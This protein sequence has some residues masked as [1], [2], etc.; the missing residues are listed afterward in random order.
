MSGRAYKNPYVGPQPLDAGQKIYGRDRELARLLNLMV[1][2]R[3]VVLHSPSGAGKSSLI[4]AGLVPHLEEAAGEKKK[5]IAVMGVVRIKGSL[6]DE[7][8][9]AAAKRS[10]PL[11]RFILSVVL[12]LEQALPKDVIRLKPEKLAR[13]KLE[14]YLDGYLE[15]RDGEA[16][17]Q[18][19]GLLI[20]DQFEDLITQD[21]YDTEAKEAFFKE[22]GRA[23]AN[24]KRAA[25]FT[26][27]EDYLAAL[28]PFA[29]H[30]PT[31]LQHTFRMDLLTEGQ[32]LEAIEGPAR[33]RDV[34]FEK[35]LAEKLVNDLRQVR[36]RDS[37]GNTKVEKGPH[38]EPVHLQ[39]LCRDLWKRKPSEAKIIQASLVDK[40]WNVDDA[41]AD[42]YDDEVDKVSRST[43]V[44]ER[45]IREWVER[46]LI[47]EDG[48]RGQVMQPKKWERGMEQEAL[49]ALVDAHL[50][51]KEVRRDIPWYELTHDRMVAPVR[52][53]NRR[54]Q[55]RNLQPFMLQALQWD[56][57]KGDKRRL[58][59]SDKELQRAEAWL[60]KKEQLLDDVEKAFLS[61]SR[62]EAQT[63]ATERDRTQK[64]EQQKLEAQQN[65]QKLDNQLQLNKVSLKSRR[66]LRFMLFITLIFLVLCVLAIL[67][68][69]QAHEEALKQ[70]ATLIV[71]NAED[72]VDEDPLLGTL[73]LIEL[74]KNMQYTGKDREDE[75]RQLPPG[76]RTT[77]LRLLSQRIPRMTFPPCRADTRVS[78]FGKKGTWVVLA[79]GPTARIHEEESG[80]QLHRKSLGKG[81][82]IVHLDTIGDGSL[83]ALVSKK[84][85]LWLWD[86]EADDLKDMDLG[87]HQVTGARFS[88]RGDR[89]YFVTKKRALCHKPLKGKKVQCLPITEPMNTARLKALQLSSNGEYLAALSDKGPVEILAVERPGETACTTSKSLDA[90]PNKGMRFSGDGKKL[91]T[92]SQRQVCTWDSSTCKQRHCVTRTHK[93]ATAYVLQPDGE[94][95]LMADRHGAVKVLDFGEGGAMKPEEVLRGHKAKVVHMSFSGG[96]QR[97]LT[98]SRDG[99]TFIWPAAAPSSPAASLSEEERRRFQETLASAGGAI[100]SPD[101]SLKIELKDGKAVLINVKH[102]RRSPLKE[103]IRSVSLACFSRG[104]DLALG[105]SDGTIYIF[106]LEEGDWP[107]DRDKMQKIK[108]RGHTTGLEWMTFSRDSQ[109]LLTLSNDG[110]ARVWRV[111]NGEP[112]AWLCGAGKITGAAFGPDINSV[113]IKNNDGRDRSWPMSWSD[114]T[115]RL[116]K[117]TKVCLLPLNRMQYLAEEE[118]EAEDGYE[119]CESAQEREPDKDGDG[120]PDDKD[121]CPDT[122]GWP[123]GELTEDGCPD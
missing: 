2:K 78:R 75:T 57:E 19:P 95:I 101:G 33:E 84:G 97:L 100:Q 63:R 11:N 104:G 35:G 108:L 111:R 96:G 60:A 102:G 10:K 16:S 29:R 61:D 1:A 59:L 23:L 6:P 99:E 80:R 105:T 118:T 25:L 107:G 52:Q 113:W 72:E 39:V 7:V 24:R 41:L 65:Q 27:R 40:T 58:L 85:Q 12:E 79:C 87:A 51:R 67:G 54:W 74:E 43:G 44:P 77:A 34:E 30:V 120:T 98:M 18:R 31:G 26:I 49:D 71:A 48:V 50:V 53:D 89:L 28:S 103:T 36:V 5:G 22:L 70:W 38:V 117:R 114:L 8:K 88:P 56:K 55:E 42:F 119:G 123:T 109:L 20:L 17:A 116:E 86:P 47:T 21:R 122:Q 15:R 92:W 93:H 83:V 68:A 46:E 73:L 115:R 112:W 45:F 13:V 64:E 76:A 110:A 91:L 94:R 32:A 62:K 9:A 106:P 121:K 81:E 14:K 4:H 66:R 82:G 37:A 90:G 69:M 3:I